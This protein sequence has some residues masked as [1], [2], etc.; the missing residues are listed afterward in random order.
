MNR[1][2]RDRIRRSVVLATAAVVVLCSRFSLSAP[3]VPTA[4]YLVQSGREHEEPQ[5]VAL[6]LDACG[7]ETLESGRSFVWWELSARLRNGQTYGVRILSERIPMTGRDGIG[8]VARYLYR[9]PAGKVFEYVD[10]ATGR[11]LLPMIRFREDFLP[12]PGPYAVFEGGFASAGRF[13]GHPIL[14]VS[15]LDSSQAPDRLSFE[16]PKVLRLQTD[17]L[18]ATQLSGR[19]DT[20]PLQP[21]DSPP[22][23]RP[24]TRDELREMIDAGI[25]LFH[26][27]G[28]EMPWLIEQ[29]VFFVRAPSFPDS[30]YRSNHFMLGRMYLDEPSVRFGWDGDI[31]FRN[32][33]GPE[34]HACAVLSRAASQLLLDALRLPMPSARGRLDLHARPAYSWDTHYYSAW[35]QLAAGVSGLVYEGRYRERGYG[36]N[37]EA[38]FGEEGLDGLTFLDQLHY[39]NAFLRGAA[40]AFDG[41]WGI[42]VYPEGDRELFAPAWRESYDMGARLFWYWT[43]PPM[44]DWPLFLELARDLRAHAAEHPRAGFRETSRGAEVGIV[45]PAGYALTPD[46][47]VWGFERDDPNRA[48]VTY[49]EVAAAAAW[50]GVLC[51]R[52]GIPFDYLVDEPFVRDLGYRRLIYVRRDATLD[53]VPPREEDRAPRTIALRLGEDPDGIPDPGGENSARPADYRVGRARGIRIDGALDDWADASWIPLRGETAGAA[54]LVETELTIPNVASEELWSKWGR[55][56]LGFEFDQL[57][58]ELQRRYHLEDYH[59]IGPDVVDE[60]RPGVSLEQGAVVVTGVRAGSPAAEAG[61]RPGDIIRAAN[62]RRTEWA[63]V[64]HGILSKMRKGSPD[65]LRLEI[66]RSPG[67]V[68]PADDLAADVALLVDDRFLYIAARVVDDV[69]SQPFQGWYLWQGDCLQLGLSPLPGRGIG[70]GPDDHELAL[71]RKDDGACVVWR[72]HGRRGMPRGIV[73]SA[74]LQVVREDGQ[75][76]YEAAIPLEELMPLAPGLLPRAAFNLVLNDHDGGPVARRKGRLELREGAMTRHKA[77]VDFAVM[78]F[79]PSPDPR[80][81]SAALLWRRRATSADAGFFRLVLACRSPAAGNARVRATLRSLDDPETP[82]VEASTQVAVGPKMDV[83]SLE[84]PVEAP[85]GRYELSVTVEGNDAAPAAADRLPVFIYP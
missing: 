59:I 5:T 75:T 15:P 63:F 80:K 69:Q 68:L 4:V 10:A 74:R 19:N 65:R 53:V 39:Q 42:S 76:R 22:R 55:S 21:G 62:G 20:V 56:Y 83:W 61:L 31:P 16:N 71:T 40:R 41:E 23:A 51:S 28:G 54:D 3:A 48:G 32:L 14:R 25:N 47:S 58:A 73:E 66:T 46:G 29:P 7:D 85:P 67:D 52:L 72:Y 64:L 9:D 8:R 57:D 27:V 77:P 13:Q 78:E 36:W 60:N 82:G 43:H 70:Y 12:V 79:E 2:K 24:Y 18:I 26:D 37:P 81:V 44:T 1:S 50:E 6:R 34:Q 45:L 35:Y 84:I 38:F 30:W 49:G 33:R 17:L 11:A